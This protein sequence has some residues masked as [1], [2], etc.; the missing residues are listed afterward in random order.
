VLVLGLGGRLGAALVVL[1]LWPALSLSSELLGILA[2]SVPIA[3]C[4]YLA[5]THR[6]WVRAS[7]SLGL[8]AGIAGALLGG[9]LG[10]TAVSDRDRAAAQ[11]QVHFAAGRLTPDELDDRL[12]AAIAVRTFGDLRRA[13]ADLP[14]PAPGLQ[15]AGRLERGYRRLL[16]FYP[17]RYRRVHEEEMLAVLMTGAPE[18][19]RRPGLAEAVGLILGALRVRCQPSRGGMPSWRGALALA[20]AGAVLGLLAGVAFAVL[21]PPLLTSRALVVIGPKGLWTPTGQWMFSLDSP[22]LL[23]ARPGIRP[24]ISLQTL[25][26]RARLRSVRRDVFSISAQGSTPAQ[27]MRTAN[28]VAR[29]YVEVGMNPNS[30]GKALPPPSC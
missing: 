29:S 28:A 21:N 26:S 24:A 20:S 23:D 12:T 19:K 14:G 10:F 18:G 7:K 9:W 30:G 11:L 1:T 27:A 22:I 3:L 16:A 6:D 8:L 4:I 17:P 5:W 15:Q 2:P 25:Q 13:L